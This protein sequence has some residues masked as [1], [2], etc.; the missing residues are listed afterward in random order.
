MYNDYN[1]FEKAIKYYEKSVEIKLKIFGENH[2]DVANV[3]KKK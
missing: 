1:D 2:Q 3:I